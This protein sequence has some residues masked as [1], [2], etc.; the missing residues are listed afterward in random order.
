MKVQQLGQNLRNQVKPLYIIS[1]ADFYFRHQAIDEFKS[2]VDEGTFDFNIAYID[3][4]EP[5]ESMLVHLQT[6]PLVSAYRVVFLTQ[7]GKK[8]EK[9]KLKKLETMLKKWQQDPCPGV[10]LVICDD[11]DCFKAL[12]KLAEVV[13][14]SKQGLAELMPL[15]GEY[16]QKH[17]YNISREVL[18]SLITKCNFDMTIITNE[19]TKLFALARDKSITNA[20]VEDIVIDNIEQNVFKLTDSIAAADMSA[21]YCIFQTL[22]QSGEQPLT[23]LAVI[24]GQYRRMFMARVSADSDAVLAGQLGVSPYAVT[25]SRRLGSKYKPMPLKKLVDRL[26]NIEFMAKSG[27][28]SAIEGVNLA[29]I[30]AMQSAFDRR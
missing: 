7:G 16:I 17:G 9:D 28:I 29:L 25:I 2:L 27:E 11:G 14:C 6:P 24:S 19:L 13:D 5:A 21:A 12:S 15:V 20:D 8:P 22:L 1:G 23:I 10:A 18:S 26:Q 4:S 30:Y 3:T